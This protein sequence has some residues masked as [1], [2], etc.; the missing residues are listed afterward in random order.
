MF[1][2]EIACARWLTALRWPEGK[3]CAGSECVAGNLAAYRNG[4]VLFCR[5]CRRSTSVTA[6]TILHGSHTDLLTWFYAAFLMTTLTPG[7]S[8]VQL[9]HQLGIA[10]YE[11]AFQLLHKL[12]SAMVNTE[13]E[14]LHGVVEVDESYIGGKQP[15]AR[16]G[17][18]TKGRALVAGAVEMRLS[19][20]GEPYA[21]R[22]RLAVVSAASASNLEG[23]VQQ[24]VI[25]GATV[26]TDGWRSYSRLGALGF[27]HQPCV[28][29]DPSRASMHLPLI[30]R[31]FSNLKTWLDGTHH[32]RV[33]R[34]HLQS[35]L[36]EFAFRHNRR[37]WRFAAS[38]RVLA[39]GI[40]RVAPTYAKIYA[41][42]Q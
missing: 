7:I 28:Q 22:V 33:E 20:K 24:H 21:G 5:T 29:G 31:E 30:H 15:E 16:K 42:P 1:P 35:Y 4:R 6:G 25:K 3:V 18:S 11:T 9:Q 26:R 32:G 27:R 2:D 23:F 41:E 10:R 14:P 37:F 34:K 40:T 8:A 38:T 17:R 13:R 39:L 36:D 12:R 19:T